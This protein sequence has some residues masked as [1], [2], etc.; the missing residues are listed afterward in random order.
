MDLRETSATER[1]CSAHERTDCLRPVIL[2]RLFAGRLRAFGGRGR[3]SAIV[4]ER[5]PGPWTI[6]KSGLVGDEQ[7][8]RRH[9]GGPD[10]ALHHYSAGHYDTWA[11]EL[12]AAASVLRSPPAFGE[13]ISTRGMTEAD[14]CI[15]DIFRV[16]DVTLQVSQ[17]RQ[18]CWKLNV[19]CGVPDMAYRVQSSGRTGWYYR[20]LEPGVIAP[21]DL[22]RLMDR[23]QPKWTL[24]R[25]SELFYRRTDAFAELEALSRVPE[26]AENWRNLAARRLAH[27]R[28]EDWTAR[29]TGD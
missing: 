27:R 26:L 4:K 22:L 18:P 15:G 21:G 23:P 7:A 29:L 5:V 9:H 24:Q 20:V 2:D 19:R 25:I 6:S 17:G 11:K 14:V 16:G 8:D 3:T 13:N 1:L 12:P 10:K 28:V